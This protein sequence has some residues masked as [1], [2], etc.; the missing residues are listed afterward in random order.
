LIEKST[1]TVDTQV[2]VPPTLADAAEK[3]RAACACKNA[4]KYTN[5]LVGGNAPSLCSKKPIS[6]GVMVRAW[7][8]ATCL[9]GQ[10]CLRT[11]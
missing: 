2:S 7:R 4:K 11:G 3:V 8:V 10:K 9:R 1:R 6:T 5:S